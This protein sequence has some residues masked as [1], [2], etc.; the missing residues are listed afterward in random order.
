MTDQATDLDNWTQASS[1]PLSTGIDLDYVE[2][3]DPTGVPVL[4]LH[5]ARR[6]HRRSRVTSCHLIDIAPANHPT[7]AR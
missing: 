4:L 7:S 5:G 1:I 2:L 6:P 3:G